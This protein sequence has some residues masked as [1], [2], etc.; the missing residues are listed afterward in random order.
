MKYS[1]CPEFCDKSPLFDPLRDVAKQLHEF[2]IW[3]GLEDYQRLLDSRLIPIK[4]RT[5]QPLRIVKKAAKPRNF[6]DHYAPRIYS[7]G[8]IQTR[9]QNWHDFF[10]LLTW[11]L[12]PKT[13][14][15]INSLHIPH[16]RKR[17]A[18]GI[19]TGR[20]SLLENMLSL[21][22]EGGAVIVSSDE[23]LLS[24]IQEFKWKALFWR[25][26]SELVS[27]LNCVVFGHALYEK[28][29]SP[30]QGMTANSILVKVD[31]AFFKR[32]CSD[33]L[34]EIDSLLEYYLD[35]GNIF[36][37]PHDL[38][39]FPLLGMPGWDK[40]NEH[41][42]YYDNHSYFRSGRKAEGTTISK[43]HI[44]CSG[45]N[46]PEIQEFLHSKLN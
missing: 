8:E 43:R 6:S 16:A 36:N 12:F 14:S 21:F 45:A 35:Q 3:P 38:S 22:D 20:R 7:R 10:Q 5:G 29:L 19:D 23:S 15:L 4:T 42:N 39:P 28:A 46:L 1:W 13:K 31:P 18:S 26:R 9:D 17:M 40:N 34:L 37:R 44:L 32:K 2:E 24:L 41:E 27:R 11:I 25:R 33:Q 30:Y